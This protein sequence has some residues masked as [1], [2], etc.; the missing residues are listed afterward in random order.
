LWRVVVFGE[1][2]ECGAPHY[3][4]EGTSVYARVVS[5]TSAIGVKQRDM[6]FTWGFDSV[7]AEE[8]HKSEEKKDVA[9]NGLS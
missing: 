4:W 9:C 2:V 3:E 6:T 8:L 5:A 7:E 1:V